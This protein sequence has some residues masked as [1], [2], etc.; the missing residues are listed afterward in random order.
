MVAGI[1]DFGQQESRRNRDVLLHPVV[2]RHF[3]WQY[4][5]G[6]LGHHHR[7]Q[8][9]LETKTLYTTINVHYRWQRSTAH[10][11]PSCFPKTFASLLFQES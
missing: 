1:T 7:I 2:V 5:A 6:L 3:G 8:Q 4:A 11:F 9:Y 10:F